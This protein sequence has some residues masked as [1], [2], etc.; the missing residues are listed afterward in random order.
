MK[1]KN[2]INGLLLLDKPIGLSSN[3]ALQKSK[4]IFNAKK[5]GHTGSLDPLA[6]G[7]LPICFGEATKFTQFLLDADKTYETTAKLGAI[8]DTGDAEGQVIERREIND[9]SL[10]KIKAVLEKFRGEQSQIPPMYSALKQQGKPLYELARAG[11]SVPREPRKI[12]IHQLDLVSFS[13]DELSLVVRCSKGTYIRSLVEDIGFALGCGAHVVVLRRTAVAGFDAGKMVTMENLLAFSEAKQ[14]KELLDA[15]LPVDSLV[16]YLPSIQ[17]NLENVVSLKKGQCIK[18][19][20]TKNYGSELTLV[21]VYDSESQF[22]GLA[23]LS[24]EGFLKPKRLL[25]DGVRSQIDDLE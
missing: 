1:T 19:V 25:R 14:E 11:I 7:M 15:L 5:A 21:R 2:D 9:I 3:A 6:T 23:E 20:D 13:G 24:L 10:E 22:I 18:N 16:S 4:R 17:L 8:T 12:I